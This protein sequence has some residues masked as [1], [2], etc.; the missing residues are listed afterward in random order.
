MIKITN[1]L[2]KVQT[3]HSY[4]ESPD[5]KIYNLFFFRKNY[6]F[7]RKNKLLQMAG[8]PYLLVCVQ[9]GKSLSETSP[10]IGKT[11]REEVGHSYRALKCPDSIAKRRCLKD[12]C[13]GG[14]GGKIYGFAEGSL[15][16]F[17]C[18]ISLID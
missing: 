2:L 5:G 4:F 9:V 11:C 13:K 14:H 1:Y 18:Y 8:V 7:S 16:F 10:N 17:N 6:S 3:F 12:V 15:H